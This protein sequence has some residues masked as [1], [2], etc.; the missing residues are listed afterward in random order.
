MESSLLELVSVCGW[1]GRYPAALSSASLGLLRGRGSLVAAGLGDV[2]RIFASN[3][4][5]DVVTALAYSTGL[6]VAGHL[7]LSL[8]R[9]VLFAAAATQSCA[10]LTNAVST[11]VNVC[12]TNIFTTAQ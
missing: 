9:L 11:S 3:A 8:V 2:E 10:S 4:Y 6:I 5:G 7:S 1:S 12:P